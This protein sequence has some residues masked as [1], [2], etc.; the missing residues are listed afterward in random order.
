MP[1]VKRGAKNHS[2]IKLRETGNS[3]SGSNGVFRIL[4]RGNVDENRV[5]EAQNGSG[6]LQ[7]LYGFS[8]LLYAFIKLP[9]VIHVYL[10]PKIDG[11]RVNR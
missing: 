11:Q 3:C 6:R 8:F 10:L 9:S 7:L 2:N 4:L 1:A 5:Y